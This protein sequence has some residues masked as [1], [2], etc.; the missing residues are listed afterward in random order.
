[1]E[2][3]NATSESVITPLVGWRF[4][5]A[6]GSVPTEPTE[7][8][9]YRPSMLYPRL[10]PDIVTSGYLA[11]PTTATAGTLSVVDS[12]GQ[13]AQWELTASTPTAVVAEIGEPALGEVGLP[14]FTVTLDRT[15]N[16]DSNPELLG[17]LAE[18]G[19]DYLVADLTVTSVGEPFTDFIRPDEF[20]FTPANGPA[21]RAA[22][23]GAVEDDAML[24]TV[25][26]GDSSPFRVAF[27]TPPGPGTL[28]MRDAAGRTVITWRVG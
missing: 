16:T 4:A 18:S 6:D 8:G 27:A 1:M 25:G 22:D 2:L 20:V 23:R 3:T 7:S 28:E 19:T 17:I 10:A 24:V 15:A 12:T 5:P 13:L 21:V 9:G 26:H 14:A 11:F